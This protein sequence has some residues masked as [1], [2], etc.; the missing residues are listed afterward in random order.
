MIG[1]NGVENL[2]AAVWKHDGPQHL[3]TSDE[4]LQGEIESCDVE[5]VAFDFNGDMSG[6]VAEFEDA[7]A[8]DPVGLLDV[9]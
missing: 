3:V 7:G 2:L 5:A 6:D 4:T 8:A 1:R 9:G